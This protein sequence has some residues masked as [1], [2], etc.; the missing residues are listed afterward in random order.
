MAPLKGY[1]AAC[2]YHV[3]A[4]AMSMQSGHATDEKHPL[5]ILT[6]G[7]NWKYFGSVRLR[8]EGTLP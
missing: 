7:C 2:L 4:L 5:K 8:R 6:K 1:A 3:T